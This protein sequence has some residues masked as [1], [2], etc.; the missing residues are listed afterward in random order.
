[1]N[2][3]LF[4]LRRRRPAP[5]A[6]HAVTEAIEALPAEDRPFQYL[7]GDGTLSP[8]PAPAAGGRPAGEWPY[9]PQSG[10]DETAVFRRRLGPVFRPAPPAVTAPIP[11]AGG[12]HARPVRRHVPEAREL[13]EKVLDGLRNLPDR[14]PGPANAA[15]LVRP[16][17]TAE[18]LRTPPAVPGRAD[19]FTADMR[20]RG[21]LPVF[22]QTA[23]AAGWLGLDADG[24]SGNWAPW[25][26]RRTAAENL[27]AV[28]AAAAAAEAEISH[29]AREIRQRWARAWQAAD[30]AP[31]LGYPGSGL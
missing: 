7:T 5:P 8:L 2:V 15:V 17:Y 12:Q 29:D 19:R 1:V 22:R 25:P 27:S 23:H 28:I 10:G 6:R 30:I 11:A 18:P 20:H 26:T 14:D 31:A 3:T 16:P 13:L 9:A 21:G 24:P 4:P